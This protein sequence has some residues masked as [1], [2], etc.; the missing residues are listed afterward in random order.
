MPKR[1]LAI[2]RWWHSVAV[3]ASTRGLPSP[4]EF[5]L[6]DYDRAEVTAAMRLLPGTWFAQFVQSP[7]WESYAPLDQIGTGGRI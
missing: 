6:C 5:K 2:D 3:P 4:T 1:R 7:D